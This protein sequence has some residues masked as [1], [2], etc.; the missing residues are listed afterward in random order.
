MIIVDSLEEEE[1]EMTEEDK[2][3]ENISTYSKNRDHLNIVTLPFHSG[4]KHTNSTG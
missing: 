1:E 4:E 3:V 2:E